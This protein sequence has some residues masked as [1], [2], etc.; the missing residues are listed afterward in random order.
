MCIVIKIE[1]VASYPGL[2]CYFNALVFKMRT[3]LD[4]LVKS[5]K[6][7]FLADKR[8]KRFHGIACIVGQRGGLEQAGERH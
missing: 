2:N 1:V 6:A 7:R 4:R 5:G 8:L 3:P